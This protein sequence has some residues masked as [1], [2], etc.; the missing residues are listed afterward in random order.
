MWRY[1]ANINTLESTLPPTTLVTTTDTPLLR[2]ARTLQLLTATATIACSVTMRH[3]TCRKGRKGWETERV[4]ED[5]LQ[6]T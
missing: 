6:G 3:S 5:I 4:W 2:Y 1:T